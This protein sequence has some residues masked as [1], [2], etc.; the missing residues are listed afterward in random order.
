M[1]ESRKLVDF[2]ILTSVTVEEDRIG[3]TS[4]FENS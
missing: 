4:N 2:E 1:N 3:L